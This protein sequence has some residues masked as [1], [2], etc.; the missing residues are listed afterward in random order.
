VPAPQAIGIFD[1]VLTV[2][3]HF[4]A[5]KTILARRFP[6]IPIVGIFIARRVFANPLAESQ[7]TLI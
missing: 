5:M 6:T 4:V 7:G 3:T 1:D 2:G